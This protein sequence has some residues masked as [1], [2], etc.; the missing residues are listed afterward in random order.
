[1]LSKIHYRNFRLHKDVTL[2]LHPNVNVFQG[3]SDSGKSCLL[4]GIDWVW[5]G[6]P[7][8]DG[9]VR[10][11][12]SECHVEITTPENA[13]K[14]VRMKG[15]SSYVLNGDEDHPLKAFNTEVPKEVISI[16]GFSEHASSSQF[17]SPFVVCMTGGEIARML[18]TLA[19]LDSI[20]TAHATVAGLFRTTTSEL[21]TLEHRKQELEESLKNTPDMQKQ[22]KMLEQMQVL[23]DTTTDARQRLTK[24]QSDVKDLR[25]AERV[26][27]VWKDV[28]GQLT[29]IEKI[30]KQQLAGTSMKDRLCDLQDRVE[31]MDN[32][33]KRILDYQIA[34]SGLATQIGDVKTVRCS[35]CG[36]ELPVQTRMTG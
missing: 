9:V 12:Q 22:E 2:D 7:R 27:A 31:Q 32:T 17:G 10:H 36:T 4:K 15:T 8:G 26:L 29:L 33:A 21:D 14:K 1:M 35:K 23:L 20:D 5:S 16:L 25:E 30:Q 3:S 13:V 19:D 18:N 24:F 34:I 28:D 6:K 11:G